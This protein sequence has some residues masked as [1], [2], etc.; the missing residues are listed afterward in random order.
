MKRILILTEDPATRASTRRTLLEL[1]Y[2]VE[3]RGSP[4]K[5]M[6]RVRRRR[7][8]SAVIVDV[9]LGSCGCST[10]IEACRREARPAEMPILVLAA[11]PRAAVDAI[12]AGAQGCVKAPV[13]SATLLPMLLQVNLPTPN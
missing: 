5:A 6:E 11:T 9:R 13:D 10:F 2:D 8:P 3:L 12:R 4:A 1:G 7:R